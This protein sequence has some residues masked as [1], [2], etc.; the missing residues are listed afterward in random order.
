MECI[1]YVVER[2]AKS[3]ELFGEPDPFDRC[4]AVDPEGICF[5]GDGGPPRAEIR[6]EWS[7][8][9]GYGVTRFSSTTE[10]EKLTQQILLLLRSML[11][12]PI[13]GPS[14]LLFARPLDELVELSTVEP[15]T[16][17]L[18]A[19]VDLDPLTLGHQQLCAVHWTVHAVTLSGV[20]LVREHACLRGPQMSGRN[21][22][23][24]RVG[25]R[26]LQRHLGHSEFFPYG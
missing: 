22:P 12:L 15:H 2:E 11:R 4:F 9:S 6:R 5:K 20:L 16:S 1:D 7:R 18:W 23:A 19:V 25:K 17:A 26:R 8:W 24:N 10:F 3:L 13:A 14:W 21:H